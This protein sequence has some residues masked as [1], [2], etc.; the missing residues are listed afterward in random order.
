MDTLRYNVSTQF[1]G[2]TSGIIIQNQKIAPILSDI[3][4]ICFW[5]KG[6]GDNGGR[7]IYFSS[8]NGSPFWCLEK[9]T[10]NKFRYDWNGSPDQYSTDSILDDV[11]TYICLVRESST[12]AKFYING[13]YKQTFTSST[14]SLTNLVDTWRIGRDVRS[15]D[16]TPY[17]GLMSDFRIYCTALTAE[18]VKELYNTSS[19]IDK[20]G[21]VYAREVIEK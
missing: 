12:S 6:Q 11:W 15:N 4:T 7:S 3:C 18:Q 5:I 20:N 17:S 1:N 10:G 2:T 21:N 9:S 19:T 14:A 16:G 13:E 8:Y